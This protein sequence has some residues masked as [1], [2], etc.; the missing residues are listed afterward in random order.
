MENIKEKIHLQMPKDNGQTLFYPDL[1]Q[2]IDDLFSNRNNAINTSVQIGNLS[3]LELKEQARAELYSILQIEPSEAIIAVGNKPVFHHCGMLAKYFFAQEIAKKTNGTV[4]NFII[5]TDNINP[6]LCLPGKGE[7]GFTIHSIPLLLEREDI[8]AEFQP[9]PSK[10]E[11]N[12]FREI[13]NSEV[14]VQEFEDKASD[15]I[16][17][18]FT[19]AKSS[20]KL[21]ELISKINLEYAN[22]LGLQRYDVSMSAISETNSFNIFAHYLLDQCQ[23]TW[24]IYNKTVEEFCGTESPHNCLVKRLESKDGWLEMPF[25]LTVPG[26]HALPLFI[27]PGDMTITCGNDGENIIGL[28]LPKDPS[29]LLEHLTE[30]ALRIRPR[31]VTYSIFARLFLSDYFIHGINGAVHDAFTDIFIR[32]FMNIEPPYYGCASATVLPEFKSSKARPEDIREAEIRLAEAKHKLRDFTCN[33]Q[34]YVSFEDNTEE[35]ASL[36][37]EKVIL[38]DSVAKL[39][40]NENNKRERKA[41]FEEIHNIN[42]TVCELMP[43]I[44]DKID[45][46]IKLA[47]RQL[48]SVK[49]AEF[50]ELFFGLFDTNTL[51]SLIKK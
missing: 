41:I 44:R 47:V 36:L 40:D 27:R 37:K 24:E 13:F 5:N 49:A 15:L 21:Y 12:R 32:K 23:N 10:W 31:S 39:K 26:M 25:W 14:I 20:R 46:E 42:A 35:V 16:E 8:S 17:L 19:Q 43:D 30:T 11:L 28:K 6:V 2:V 34:K 51:K 50:R 18:I 3:F 38:L 33:P 9:C 4:V 1:G 29:K 7:N 22:K 48:N 45:T